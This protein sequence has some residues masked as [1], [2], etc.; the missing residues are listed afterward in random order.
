MQ[1]HHLYLPLI[2]VYFLLCNKRGWSCGHIYYTV[3][4]SLR[5]NYVVNL[6]IGKYQ[7]KNLKRA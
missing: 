7:G 5:Y 4:S 2:F 1:D 6:F 3:N